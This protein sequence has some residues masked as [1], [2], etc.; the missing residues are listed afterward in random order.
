MGRQMGTK[1]KVYRGDKHPHEAQN[2]QV[3]EVSA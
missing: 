3:L 1:L 2:P